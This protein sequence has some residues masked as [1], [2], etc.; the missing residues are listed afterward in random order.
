MFRSEG[1]TQKVKLPRAQ[2]E[3]SSIQMPEATQHNGEQ[4]VQILPC[5]HFLNVQA[6]LM[7]F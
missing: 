2:K 3:V 6:M 1:L 7:H 4:E 5:N